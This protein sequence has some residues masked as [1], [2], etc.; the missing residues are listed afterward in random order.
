M[1]D[2]LLLIIGGWVGILRLCSRVFEVEKMTII[3]ER[4]RGIS[5]FLVHVK[6]V[7]YTINVKAL[8]IDR[9]NTVICSRKISI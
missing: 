8:T 9:K 4:R 6:D 5:S 2:C 3:K 7:Q 1:A